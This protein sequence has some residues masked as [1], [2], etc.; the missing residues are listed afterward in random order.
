MPNQ[1]PKGRSRSS[2]RPAP[3]RQVKLRLATRESA[4]GQQYSLV[5]GLLS[6]AL[7]RQLTQLQP[8][9]IEKSEPSLD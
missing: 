5:V 8:V 4:G 2:Q 1:D 9:N 6:E 3:A 7:F